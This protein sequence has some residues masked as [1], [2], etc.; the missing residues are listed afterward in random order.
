MTG[1]NQ[2]LLVCI[3]YCCYVTKQ[4][5]SCLAI[6]WAYLKVRGKIIMALE[7]LQCLAP[8]LSTTPGPKRSGMTSTLF[9][10]NPPSGGFPSAP[11]SK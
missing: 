1:G 4:T 6:F 2:I 9:A 7:I 3:A 10:D 5:D 11:E 8:N